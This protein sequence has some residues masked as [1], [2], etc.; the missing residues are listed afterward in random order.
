MAH[1]RSRNLVLILG[2]A[3]ADF[4]YLSN[5]SNSNA[6]TS[7]TLATNEVWKDKQTQQQQERSEY[8]RCVAFGKTADYLVKYARKGSLIDI[9]G[10]LQTRKWQDQAGQDRYTTEIKI[11]SAQ[12]IDGWKNEE[13]RTPNTSNKAQAPEEYQDPG[14]QQVPPAAS[15]P[16]MDIPESSL[17]DDVPGFH[18]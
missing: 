4:T 7:F 12:I 8:H 11:S 5:N 16:A 6:G 15:H 2:N 17:A 3:T 10:Q 1:R 18:R 13:S 14:Y 9:E